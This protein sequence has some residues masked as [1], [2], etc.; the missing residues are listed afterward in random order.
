MNQ[1]TIRDY[2]RQNISASEVTPRQV[3]DGYRQIK[4]RTLMGSVLCQLNRLAE[5]GELVKCRRG[6]SVYFMKPG[7]DKHPS[8]LSRSARLD[9]LLF[10]VHTNAALFTIGASA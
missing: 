1:L 5:N 4:P 10:S 2:V 7:Q 9:H 3:L 6:Q 8:L